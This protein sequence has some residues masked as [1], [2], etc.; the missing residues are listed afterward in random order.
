MNKRAVAYLLF[1][2]W[3]INS[4]VSSADDELILSTTN[5]ST[6]FV[7]QQKC[8]E[9]TFMIKGSYECFDCPVGKYQPTLPSPNSLGVCFDCP[10]GTFTNSK[11]SSICQLCPKGFACPN[12]G[13]IKPIPCLEDENINIEG[14]IICGVENNVKKEAEKINDDDNKYY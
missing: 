6:S 5:K 3:I 1:N 13:M 11:A 9:G 12:S 10:I 4:V 8:G 14:G 7:Q 2:F